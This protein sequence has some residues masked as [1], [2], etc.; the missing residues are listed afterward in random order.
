M[1]VVHSI[2]DLRQIVAG[3][4]ALGLKVAIVPT[5]GNL[6]AGHLDLVFRARIAADRVVATVFVNP[7]QFGPNEDFDR[8]PRTL[9]SDRDQLALSGCDVLFA[10]PESEVYPQ[11][12]TGLT[13]VRAAPLGQI[14]EGA[15]RPGFFDGVATVVTILF[16]LVQPDVACF[17]QKD[18]QQ[19][20]VIRRLVADL[21]LPI[22]ILPVET[23]R[24][25]DGLAMSSRNQY[26]G[27]E[28]RRRAPRL[29]ASLAAI[30]SGMRA[31]RRDF[32]GLCDEQ[33]DVL[34]A[35]GFVPQYLDIRAADLSMP[36]PSD[37]Q[38]VVLVAAH[39]GTTRLIDNRIIDFFDNPAAI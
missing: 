11:G 16:N 18:Y 33:M 37:R 13:G 39:L 14:L 22:E 19:L 1:D 8:Y 21:H 38:F 35:E 9:E 24:E 30:E 25:P 12:R 17:G 23:R 36:V 26:L 20:Q 27:P 7:L 6:H 15:F 32:D 28:E 3:W 2:A 5:M 10:P 29:A 34:R 31:G 4:R